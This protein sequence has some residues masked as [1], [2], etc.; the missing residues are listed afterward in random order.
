MPATSSLNSGYV[1]ARDLLLKNIPFL[2]AEA[3]AYLGAE[4]PNLP[5]D[6]TTCKR[7]VKYIVWSIV[8]DLMY[9][10]NSQSVY[11]GQMYWDGL[12][13]RI[14]TAEVQPITDVLAYLNGLMQLIIVNDLPSTTYQQSI[15]QYTNETYI[16]GVIAGSS[17]SSNV[18]VISDIINDQGLTPV[19]VNP[20]VTNSATV[21]QNVEL[22]HY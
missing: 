4:Y 19:I 15:R 14:A 5:Y 6:K 16:G 7:D 11:A 12:V 21:L 2:Q 9:E 3:V 17:I 8:Y 18:G 22:A 10:G 13:R 20:D 1:S